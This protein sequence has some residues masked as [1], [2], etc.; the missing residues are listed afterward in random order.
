MESRHE[1]IHTDVAVYTLIDVFD[2]TGTI[3]TVGSPVGLRFTTRAHCAK[4]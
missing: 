2:T 1:G 4:K 3:D